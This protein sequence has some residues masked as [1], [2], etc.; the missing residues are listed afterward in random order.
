MC[1]CNYVCI[2][3]IFDNFLV[4]STAELKSATLEAEETHKVS[5]RWISL[6]CLVSSS[7]I[8]R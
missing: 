2:M 1:L 7:V 3:P 8:L 6:G 4:F 5:D